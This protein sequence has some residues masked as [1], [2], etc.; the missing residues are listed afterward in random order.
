[1]SRLRER[2]SEI[3]RAR[4]AAGGAGARLAEAASVR[5]ARPRAA[6]RRLQ[7]FLP[8]VE[9]SGER[10]ACWL[11]RWPLDDRALGAD[12]VASGIARGLALSLEG[13]HV[14]REGTPP[15]GNDAPPRPSASPRGGILLLD[16]ETT[17][18]AGTPLFL[19]GFLE[20]GPGRGDCIEQ[21]F[22]RDYSEEAALL[23][24]LSSR[25]A[26]A[27]L[28]VTFNGKTFDVPFLRDRAACHH[29][30]IADPARHLDLLH[31][32]RRIYRGI[33][34]NCRLQTL[35]SHMGGMTRAGDVPGWEIP[36]RYHDAVRR[37]DPSGLFGVFLH[38]ARDL[39]TLARLYLE[40][41][42]GEDSPGPRTAP[43]V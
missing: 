5:T 10:G 30:A 38:N 29:I 7:D 24:A 42:G 43:T 1:M 25:L 33:L 2:L 19:A 27:D 26:R 21:L 4:P 40:V 13:L 12:A 6:P 41:G 39:L 8:G 23:D 34:P 18:F 9:V 14:A 31:P 3:L 20:V 35:E 17:G 32:A 11:G 15:P 37:G 16:L 36:S 22:A 28:L